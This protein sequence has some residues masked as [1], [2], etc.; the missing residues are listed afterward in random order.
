MSV[1]YTTPINIKGIQTSFLFE[2]TVLGKYYK[3]SKKMHSVTFD[4]TLL[5]S[6]DFYSANMLFYWVLELA[7]KE[8]AIQFITPHSEQTP[9]KVKEILYGHGFLKELLKF[10]VQITHFTAEMPMPGLGLK[11]ITFGEEEKENDDQI[12]QQIK[13]LCNKHA[14]I[15]SNQ[16]SKK[17]IVNLIDTIFSTITFELIENMFLHSKSKLNYYGVNLGQSQEKV[18]T[19]KSFLC[20]FRPG[21][22]YIELYFGDTGNGI[23]K[24][25]R[26]LLKDSYQPLYP[27][28]KPLII[29]EKT[30]AYSF[31]FSSTRDRNE[32]AHRLKKILHSLD[33]EPESIATGLFCVLNL[34][35]RLK[36]QLLIRS[37]NGLLNFNFYDYFDRPIMFG[38]NSLNL[39]S[40]DNIS[41]SL[42]II[43]IP[44]KEVENE[45]ITVPT[46]H[47]NFQ[48]LSKTPYI[49]SLLLADDQ[50]SNRSEENCLDNYVKI[51]DDA[52]MKYRGTLGGLL[53]ILTDRINA[54]SLQILVSAIRSMNH[55][56]RWL[57][58]NCPPGSIVKETFLNPQFKKQG[59]ALLVGESL[60]NEYIFLGQD[61]VKFPQW[62]VNS[63]SD[64]YYVNLESNVYNNIVLQYTTIIDQKLES[65]LTSDSVWQKEGPFLIENLYYTET[66]FEVKKALTQIHIKTIFLS[67]FKDRISDDVDIILSPSASI[68][69]FLNELSISLSNGNRNVRV[70]VC[71]TK[72]PFSILGQLATTEVS[73]GVIIAD[74]VCSCNN[75]KKLITYAQKI[76]IENIFAF[77][78]ASFNV[79]NEIVHKTKEGKQIINITSIVQ[80]EVQIHYDLPPKFE[81]DSK[82]QFADSH[83]VYVIDRKTNSPT[84]YVRHSYENTLINLFDKFRR[85]AID[86]SAIL[87][88][89]YLIKDIHY[90]Y[91]LNFPA[92][93]NSLK[94]D[95]INWISKNIK[96][97]I[98]TSKVE[99]SQLSVRIYNPDDSL[100]W[101]S[102]IFKTDF[103]SDDVEFV[104]DHI[105]LA[106]KPITK[107]N[108][109]WIVLS[110]AISSGKTATLLIEYISRYTPD[111]ITYLP[112]ISRMP[113]Y[114]SNFFSGIRNYRGSSFHYSAFLNYSVESF[115]VEA[116]TCPHCSTNIIYKNI[117]KDISENLNDSFYLENA[118]ERKLSKNQPIE[119]K[120]NEYFKFSDEKNEKFVDLAYLRSLY[121]LGCLNIMVR[122]ELHQVL[123]KKGYLDYFLEVISIEYA[124]DNFNINQ[125]EITLYN[126]FD[127]VLERAKQL[128]NQTPPFDIKIYINAF[129]I[130]IP[131]EFIS[132]AETLIKNYLEDINQ[133]ESICLGLIELKSEPLD[134][135]NLIAKTRDKDAKNLLISTRNYLQ[136]AN[137][138]EN[139]QKKVKFADTVSKLW[140]WFMRSS[141]FS[142]CL[143]DLFDLLSDIDSG[144]T[145][146]VKSHLNG[147]LNDW[148]DRIKI[149]ILQLRKESIEWIYLQSIN[150][151]LNNAVNDL[152]KGILKIELEVSKLNLDTI[153]KTDFLNLKSLISTSFNNKRVIACALDSMIMA[154]TNCRIVHLS[155]EIK[156]NE[157]ISLLLIKEIEPNLGLVYC[158]EEDLNYICDQ[159]TQ[160]WE[161]HFNPSK[162]KLSVW[163]KIY[164]HQ[165]FICYEFGD[166]FST[167]FN[168]DHS[169]GSDIKKAGG[170]SFVD[171]KCKKYGGF[172]RTTLL[173]D[174]NY[175]SLRVYLPQ[176]T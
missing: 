50:Q 37:S 89:H 122:K 145:D 137:S 104:D 25:L 75:I 111:S 27:T 63:T 109:H 12:S 117:L 19:D 107:S 53:L 38:K 64:S 85:A 52:V 134:F 108:G 101:A 139:L 59:N 128:L 96:N 4:I 161:K 133:I 144:D 118:I 163:L 6:I 165:N 93:F 135:I 141:Q 26:K 71:D 132:N 159:A 67:W 65:I 112:V 54:R 81:K 23:I 31:E 21:T 102:E 30:L 129:L 156:I 66:F 170:L 90:T 45:Y 153:N 119:L 173:D 142:D 138:P 106:P 42:F 94:N 125:L 88:G 10:N 127:S 9:P 76:E 123:K 69:D 121:S 172:A 22:E 175:K 124:S 51:I 174:K 155:N 152:I 2:T 120:I 56:K 147:L 171:E 29:S 47:R 167:E 148:N 92:L 74:V 60:K 164:K 14:E 7:K 95:I 176:T 24:D 140:S 166:N 131:E 57:M 20:D 87:I 5:E 55:G 28:T 40:L 100:T 151:N 126:D 49:I 91:C 86:T 150:S 79:Q 11:T 113:S 116:N 16:F 15:I 70:L 48:S 160:N 77:V 72:K 149:F 68:A 62:L 80:K 17:K 146:N 105:L 115:P 110:P 78:D 103:A 157:V 98:K 99:N 136:Y 32:R 43:R 35:H 18:K 83:Q 169:A 168:N 130:L 8:I 44:L 158:R 34:V 46:I 143:D 36:G 39:K 61:T 1:D 97:T 154:A 114:Q 73:K 41:G 84:L 33:F 82:N 13:Q 162:R 3:K 58:L